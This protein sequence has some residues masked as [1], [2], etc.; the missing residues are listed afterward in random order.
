MAAELLVVYPENGR[1]WD[2]DPFHKFI[3]E[4]P[5]FD[6]HGGSPHAAPSDSLAIEVPTWGVASDPTPTTTIP[7]RCQ[8]A[9][10]MIPILKA[11]SLAQDCAK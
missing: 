4:R 8:M 10:I 5:E 3:Y 7:V 11:N 6:L 9:A 2:D 1:H